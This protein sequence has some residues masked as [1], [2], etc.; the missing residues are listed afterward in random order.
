[1]FGSFRT[2]DDIRWRRAVVIMLAALL[3]FAAIGITVAFT[4][5]P[6]AASNLGLG[7]AWAKGVW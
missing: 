6:H 2:N 4:A 1:M 3:I 7:V 5:V